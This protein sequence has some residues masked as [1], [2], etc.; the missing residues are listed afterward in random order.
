MTH[1]IE[2]NADMGEYLDEVSHIAETELMPLISRCNI[3]CGGHCGTVETMVWTLQQAALHNV[4]CGAHPSYPD[5]EGFG[6]R[7]WSMPF[8]DLSDNLDEQVCTLKAVSRQEG[9]VL[10]HLKPHGQLYADASQDYSLAEIIIQCAKRHD[11][12]V[13]GAPGSALESVALND[14]CAFLREGFIDRGYAPNG[15]L[16]PRGKPGAMIETLEGRLEQAVTL[17]RGRPLRLNS[18]QSLSLEIDSLCIHSDSPGAV[19]T[20]MAVRQRFSELNILTAA[21]DPTLV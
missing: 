16:I 14:Q 19:E 3:A 9:M 6:R 5:R 20:A 21:A 10:S 7:S 18:G 17:A 15:G 12:A 4:E 2:L 1:Q 11:L 13:M 8:E